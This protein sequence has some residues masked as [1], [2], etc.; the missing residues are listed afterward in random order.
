MDTY[1]GIIW[2]IGVLI[3]VLVIGAFRNRIELL[4]NFVLRGVLGMMMIYLG[5]Y[6][7]SGRVPGIEIGYNPITFLTAGVLGFPGVLMLYGIDF[8]ML[9]QQVW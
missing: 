3:V 8:Y 7:L 1:S 4:I 9:I 2:I 5:N 6:V